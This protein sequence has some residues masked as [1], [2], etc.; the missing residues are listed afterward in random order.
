MEED[1]PGAKR[2][3]A[4]TGH[5]VLAMLKDPFLS[6]RAAHMTREGIK[7]QLNQ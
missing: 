1:A 5:E 3:K 2:K 4:L 6:L 7:T